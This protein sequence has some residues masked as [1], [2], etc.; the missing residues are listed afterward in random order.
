[1]NE[2]TKLKP[3]E[4]MEKYMSV[5][6]YNWQKYYVDNLYDILPKVSY[7]I[8]S[9]GCTKQ[10]ARFIQMYTHLSNMKEND[11]VV[12]IRPNGNLVLNRKEFVSYLAKEFGR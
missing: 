12:V 7:Y 9:R 2:I 4:F 8:S 3:S 6:L 11:K 1:M 5:G 10:L